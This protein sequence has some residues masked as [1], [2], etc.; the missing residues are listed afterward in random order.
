MPHHSTINTM[1][2]K[3]SNLGAN[4]SCHSGRTVSI[5]D[6]SGHS[7]AIS[8][9]SSDSSSFPVDYKSCMKVK[10]QRESLSKI[11]N[12]EEGGGKAEPMSI[13]LEAD[14]LHSS[15][16]SSATSGARARIRFDKIEM[17]EYE[18]SLSDNPSTTSGPPIGIGWKYNPSATVV[19]DIEEYEVY[20]EKYARSKSELAIP[21]RTRREMLQEAGFSKTEIATA[22][23]RARKDKDRRNLSVQNQKYDPLAEKVDRVKQGIKRTVSMKNRKDRHLK[24]YY[25]KQ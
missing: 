6:A 23:R 9:K 20:K 18:R 13:I 15:C 10:T 8:R 24:T 5:F 7:E 22:V 19:M 21:A 1:V 2:M 16:N 4:D 12:V 25:G 14:T 11:T 17:R 3:V